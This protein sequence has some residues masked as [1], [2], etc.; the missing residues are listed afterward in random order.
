MTREE[1]ED[2]FESLKKNHWKNV[3]LWAMTLVFFL[4]PIMFPEEPTWLK[5]TILVIASILTIICISYYYT[6]WATKKYLKET[7]KED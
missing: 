3:V 5:T 1:I 6:W 4:L 7:K 2:R